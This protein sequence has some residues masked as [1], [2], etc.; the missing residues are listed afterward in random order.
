MAI[1]F[2][3]FFRVTAF[4]FYIS[5]RAEYFGKQKQPGMISTVFSSAAFIFRLLIYSDIL[6]F[7]ISEE[8]CHALHAYSEGR[9][10]MK[11]G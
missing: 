1:V 8:V 7:F 3:K 6:G 4:F 5:L 9:D 2:P 10:V 11:Q